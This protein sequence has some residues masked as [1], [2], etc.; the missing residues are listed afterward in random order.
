MRIFLPFCFLICYLNVNAQLQKAVI[1]DTSVVMTSIDKLDT[2]YSLKK[3]YRKGEW[4]LFYDDAHTQKAYYVLFN[5]NSYSEA[6]WYRNGQQKSE[7]HR[8]KSDPECFDMKTWHLDGRLTFSSKCY[9]DSC[10][11]LSY[12]LNGQISKKD[13][14]THDS[15][16]KYFNW[17]YRV[18]YY[19]NG[20]LKFDPTDPNG[21]RQTITS[22]YPIGTKQNQN[23]LWKGARVGPYKEWF[24]NGKLK[25]DG[26]YEVPIE[27]EYH[28]VSGDK[29]TG[30]W[31]FYDESGK[32]IKEEFYENNKLTNTISY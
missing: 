13:I 32:K 22:Y 17:H 11:M 5:G 19:E 2:S 12:Y 21:V 14:N 7:Y 6:A 15:L 1:S 20:Q 23:D 26:N 9:E 28:N 8:P 29:R 4:Q 30:K 24:E 3:I 18:E 27:T 25:V 31:T 16:S 10:V